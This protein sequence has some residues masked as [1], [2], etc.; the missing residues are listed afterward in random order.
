MVRMSHPKVE[1]TM[2]IYRMIPAV[3]V[4]AAIN[5]GTLPAAMAQEPA[6]Q[7]VPQEGAPSTSAGTEE[8]EKLKQRLASQQQEIKSLS[9]RDAQR[10]QELKSLRQQMAQLEQSRQEEELEK[11]ASQAEDFKSGIRFYGFFDFN[12][13]RHMYDS[14]TLARLFIPNTLSFALTS[15]HLYADSRITPTLGALMEVRYTF[16]P[17][18]TPTSYDVY[19]RQGEDLV[20][21]PQ[22]EYSRIGVKAFEPVDSEE[23]EMAGLVLERVHLTYTPVD[24]LNV[25]AGRFI[26]P[27]GIWNVDHGSPVVI[28]VRLPQLLLR[29]LVPLAQTGLQIY[30]RFFPLEEISLDYAI[31]VSNGRGPMEAVYDLDNNKGLGLRLRATYETASF[32][33][34]L[35]TYGYYGRHRDERLGIVVD[36]SSGELTT[37]SESREDFDELALT[38]DLLLETH[39]LRLQSEYVF[40]REIY[41]TPNPLSERDLMLQTGDPLAAASNF[42]SADNVGYAVYALLAYRLPLDPW[43]GQVAVSPYVMYEYNNDDDTKDAETTRSLT[44]G[45]NIRLLPALVLKV[46]YAA[47]EVDIADSQS[48]FTQA[49]VSF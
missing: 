34:A 6:S 12:F 15:V 10:E 45:L 2:N 32:K 14:E 29:K 7:P 19:L 30:G 21:M 23:I 1:A 41:N 43:L 28:G 27:F 44:F 26:T 46:E 11:L 22:E 35:G 20:K 18:G 24:W 49:A 5:W 3:M 48:I 42:F 25:I 37:R 40:R 9:E 38:A 33:L 47:F 4:M 13:G 36:P 8:T 16:L 39:G 17:L 31:T